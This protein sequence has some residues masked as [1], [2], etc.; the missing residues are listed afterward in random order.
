MFPQPILSDISLK[1]YDYYLWASRI[2]ATTGI[3]L[4]VDIDEKSLKEYGKWPWPR[5]RIAE[6]LEK[7]NFDQPAAVGLDIFFP[8]AEGTSL[9]NVR[10]TIENQFGISFRDSGIP[11]YLFESEELLAD[12]LAHGKFVPGMYLTFDGEESGQESTD[13]CFP[14][15]LNITVKFAEGAAADQLPLITAD[16]AV[17]NIPVLDDAVKMS[18]FVNTSPDHDGILRRVPLL[19]AY[20]GK[21]Y[22]NLSLATVIT[23]LQPATQLLRV[24]RFGVEGIMLDD[25]FIP[26][27]RKGFFT[28]RFRGPA[29]TFEYISA[30][31]ILNGNVRSGKFR[32][33]VVLVGTSAA[34]L[35][36]THHM[37]FDSIFPGVEFHA[38][39]VDN[40][41]GR[42][43]LLHPHW[44]EA[45]ETG[46]IL[47]TGLS[48]TV[49]FFRF[50]TWTGL[51]AFVLIGAGLF[52]G[53]EALFAATGIFLSPLYPVFSLIC[54]FFLVYLMKFYRSEHR[55]RKRKQEFFLMQEAMLEIITA[56][57]EARDQETGGHIRRT[58]RYLQI[59]AEELQKTEKFQDALSSEE[60]EVICRVAP[61]HDVGK[62]GIPDSILL[63]PGRLDR[64]E[65]E[66]I[67][68]HTYYGKQIIE[69]ALKRVGRNR[70]LEKALE[71]AYTHQEKWDG[72]G[73][74]QGLS[75]EE[76]PLAGR[77][78]AIADVYD[79]L[80]SKRPYKKPVRHEKAVAIMQGDSGTHFDPELIAVFMRV[81]ESFR[82][83]AIKYAESEQ[84]RQLLS[85]PPQH[86]HT[87]ETEPVPAALALHTS[88]GRLHH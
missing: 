60:T 88:V 35:Q 48:A 56:L 42:D 50:G 37:P 3:P 71:I 38:N 33:R 8:D 28:V 59:M 11:D 41:L 39:I 30:A 52:R 57:T 73:Y 51:L 76:I 81:H 36:D 2:S 19:M 65:F 16:G 66:E 82:E 34:G 55:R 79:A 78:M 9:K 80:T 72:S 68:K 18:G 85:T 24:S 5:Y 1:I 10:K 31:D 58:Q 49:L 83:V 74:P 84:E 64:D 22:P 20:Q 69:I 70:F 53:G 29:R 27:D 21:I 4:I 54:S 86:T 12:T 15:P 7:I 87:E 23:A 13:R 44:K 25:L 77:I 67:K 45:L 61:L 43:F 17:C 32:N 46:I 62:I 75:G 26:L 6:L 14:V 47:L 40:I 63:K